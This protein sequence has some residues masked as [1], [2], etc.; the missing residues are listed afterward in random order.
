MPIADIVKLGANVILHHRDLVN[1]CGC[2]EDG[3]P[4]RIMETE[5]AKP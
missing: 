3:V 4:A 5:G 1:L 2:T